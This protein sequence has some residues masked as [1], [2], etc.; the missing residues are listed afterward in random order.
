MRYALSAAFFS[1][2]GFL[3]VAPN[4]STA[5]PAAYSVHFSP[6]GGCT[7]TVVSDIAGAKQSVYVQAYLITSQPIATALAEARGRGVEVRVILDAKGAKMQG[8]RYLWLLSKNVPTTLDSRHPIAH[9]KVMIIDHRLTITGSFNFTA[10]AEN[11]NAENLLEVENG[12]LAQE[13]ENNF[14]LH[15]NHSLSETPAQTSAQP[16]TTPA[17]AT[18]APPCP[19]GNCPNTLGPYRTRRRLKEPPKLVRNLPDQRRRQPPSTILPARTDCENPPATSGDPHD[20]N[21]E[22]VASGFSPSCFGSLVDGGRRLR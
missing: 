11:E 14:R 8:S 2:A 13:Y 19:T 18:T 20:R 4:A 5:D 3:F 12:P 1:L 22:P 15:A 10:Q 21:A 7:A 9:N 6:R 17:S 16:Q